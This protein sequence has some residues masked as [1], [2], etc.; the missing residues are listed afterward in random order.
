LGVLFFGFG[1]KVTDCGF[2]MVIRD[3]EDGLA[4]AAVLYLA[5]TYDYEWRFLGCNLA[6]VTLLD[7]M[8]EAGGAG[9]INEDVAS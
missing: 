9:V 3:K 8:V 4:R 1:Y 6:L 5:M 2:E 7:G